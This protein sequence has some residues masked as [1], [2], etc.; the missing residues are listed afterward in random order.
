[1]TKFDEIYEIAADNYGLVTSSD[2]TSV[3]VERSELARYASD[4]RL[5]RRGRGVYRLVRWIP[6]PYDRFAEAVALVGEGSMVY[7]EGVL[8]MLDLAFAN[9]RKISVA[10]DKRV[11]KA[12]PSWISLVNVRDMGQRTS[13]MGVPCQHVADAILACRGQIMSERLIQAA[14]EAR[15]EGWIDKATERRLKREIGK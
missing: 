5:E 10:T 7:G 13:Y 15:C 8:A 2:A 1:M 4:G 11:R 6:T 14:K 9:P 12:L 3:G